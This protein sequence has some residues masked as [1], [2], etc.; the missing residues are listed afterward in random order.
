MMSGIGKMSKT[1][2]LVLLCTFFFFFLIPETYAITYYNYTVDYHLN[3][4]LFTLAD[5]V[6]AQK[7]IEFRS[8]YNQILRNVTICSHTSQGNTKLYLYTNCNVSGAGTLLAT[9]TTLSKGGVYDFNYNLTENQTY[10]IADEN[11]YTKCHNDTAG[12]PRPNTTNIYIS[13]NAHRDGGN[14]ANYNGGMY[15]IVN[16]QTERNYT[17]ADAV[18]YNATVNMFNATHNDSDTVLERQLFWIRANYSGDG[19]GINTATCLYNGTNMTSVHV[20]SDGNL[21]LS[22]SGDVYSLNFTHNNTGINYDIINFRA[23]RNSLARDL[24]VSINGV[25]HEIISGITI[26]LCSIGYFEYLNKS[27]SY[28]GSAGI[29]FSIRC[30]NC[31]GVNTVRI[32][33]QS[34]WNM[35]YDRFA[36]NYPSGTLTYNASTGY[37]NEIDEYHS[38]D[39]TGIWKLGANCNNTNA[40]KN[41]NV[42]S[43]M[44]NA[45]LLTITD[46]DGIEYNLTNNILVGRGALSILGTCTESFIRF[47]QINISNV[48]T[49]LYQANTTQI[50]FTTVLNGMYNATLFCIDDNGNYSVTSRTFNSSSPNNVSFISPTYGNYTVVHDNPIVFNFTDNFNA[51]ACYLY[52][53]YTNNTFSVLNYSQS[54][55]IYSILP[56]SF[57]YSTSA[58]FSTG[59]YNNTIF[60]GGIRLN[61]GNLSGSYTSP[62]IDAG[63]SVSW[64]SLYLNL[65]VCGGCEIPINNGVDTGNYTRPFNASGNVLYYRFNNVTL[66]G[67][68]NTKV[69]DYSGRNNN[70][71]LTNGAIYNVSSKI[72]GNSSCQFDGTNDYIVSELN[73]DLTG[74]PSFTVSMWI[75]IPT[76]ATMTGNYPPFLF[77]GTDGVMQAVSFSLSGTDISKFFI[78][79]DSGGQVMSG[80]F[81]NNTWHHVVWVRQGGG[82]AVTGNTLYIDNVSVSLANSGASNDSSYPNI[83]SGYKYYIQKAGASGS[84]YL[85]YT[86]DEFMIFNR[87]LSSSEVNI[88]YNR[89]IERIGVS[90]KSCSSGSCS[91]S[92]TDVP[93]L[94][95][96]RISNL[97]VSNNRYFQYRINFSSTTINESIII[98]NLSIVGVNSTSTVNKTYETATYHTLS[99]MMPLDISSYLQF[100]VECN[101]TYF[102][103]NTSILYYLYSNLNYQTPYANI[104]NINGVNFTEG[105]IFDIGSD[106]VIDVACQNDTIIRTEA[107]VTFV[108]NS[109]EVNSSVNKSTVTLDKRALSQ[110]NYSV[111]LYCL[112]NATHTDVENRTFEIRDLTA[113][114]IEWFSP[115]SDN[116]STVSENDTLYINFVASDNYL[117][118]V[119]IVCLDSLGFYR[120]NYSS[121]NIT[122]QNLWQVLNYTS[123]MP[124]IGTGY[125]NATVRDIQSMNDV[126]ST[127][128]FDIVIPATPTPTPTP[129]PTTDVGESVLSLTDVVMILIFVIIWIALFCAGIFFMLVFL[130]ICGLFGIFLSIMLISYS[131]VLAY[132]FIAVNVVVFLLG[133][134]MI[135]MGDD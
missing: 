82:T 66:D 67:E 96:D 108:S 14:F 2:P 44:P 34:L 70:G 24:N 51:T 31:A 118:S 43:V 80:S 115:L 56:L 130:I 123:S 105:I 110:G 93:E 113:P 28:I 72:F 29:N 81:T 94:L 64:N 20:R 114:S 38:F 59:T 10:C 55:L 4:N 112:D 75:N 125:C 13:R 121:D 25:T 39:F 69:R 49:V 86:L 100:Y 87:T 12:Y 36:V 16:V 41:I 109:S 63:N 45:S 19:V 62:V 120:L 23:C 35:R 61:R 54:D 22:S 5:S 57:N 92:F 127:V 52:S 27:S 77:F 18:V 60:D 84:K 73:S 68:S 26:P 128:Y 9:S 74:N 126:L 90:Y 30:P 97:S 91:E 83:A 65:D 89:G 119:S 53:N 76:G 116:S 15:V 42:N 58:D 103:Q 6:S 37:Y 88:L 101:N 7:G 122:G 3:D 48:S 32:I 11:S 21:T 117:T 133:C 106:V 46:T 104:S 71:T 124:N 102:R 107:N 8:N 33:Q 131:S 78:G 98:N 135:Y 1:T 129:T 40:S 17:I 111:R 85:K 95:S 50:N 47:S 99:Y 132:V 79:F 134:V